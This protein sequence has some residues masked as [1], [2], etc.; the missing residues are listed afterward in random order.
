MQGGAG[1]SHCPSKFP[2]VFLLILADNAL[3]KGKAKNEENCK[4]AV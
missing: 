2:V 3:C 4:H 1:S